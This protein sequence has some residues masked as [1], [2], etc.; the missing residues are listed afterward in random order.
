MDRRRTLPTLL[1]LL[2]LLPPSS[3]AQCSS[4]CPPLESGVPIPSLCTGDN[5]FMDAKASISYS[6]C[7]PADGPSEIVFSELAAA[8]DFIVVANYFVG[9]N[10][11]RRESGVYAYTSQ[12]LHDEH[13]NVVFISTVKG[14]G[15]GACASWSKTYADFAESTFDYPITSMPI[16]VADTDYS[17]RDTLFTSPFPHPS[18]IILDSSLTVRDK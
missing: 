7:S 4:Q 1:L 6:T 5:F 13:R 10:A 3:L 8:Y 9:C 18:Y 15:T 17:L 14:G 11:G 2:L 12:R 16:T